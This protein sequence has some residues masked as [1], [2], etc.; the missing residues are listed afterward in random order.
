[1]NPDDVAKILDELGNRLSQPAQHVFQ[2]SVNYVISSN[3]FY[4]VLC[5]GWIVSSVLAGIALVVW[6]RRGESPYG[7]RPFVGG[8]LGGA[9]IGTA[10]VA[11]VFLMI[12]VVALM[13]PE[14]TALQNL[15]GAIK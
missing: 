10:L 15:L 13:N 11:M 4:A 9:L 2:L 8:L 12:S 1:V 7:D 3:T 6:V 14:Y 5:V